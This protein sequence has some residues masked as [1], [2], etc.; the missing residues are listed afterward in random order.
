MGAKEKGK[1]QRRTLFPFRK[2]QILD[3][4]V[5]ISD[6]APVTMQRKAIM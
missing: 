1:T 3:I 5:G 6:S 4:R 2:V